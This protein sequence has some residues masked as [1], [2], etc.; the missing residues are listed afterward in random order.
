MPPAAGRGAP[1]ASFLARLLGVDNGPRLVRLVDV[2]RRRG[3]GEL[4]ERAR[5]RHG[6]RVA[7][8]NATTRLANHSELIVA[9]IELR[10]EEILEVG[11]ANG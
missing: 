2:R 1:G 7:D 3:R 10:V 8:L 5:K 9:V 4:D 11:V 6:E